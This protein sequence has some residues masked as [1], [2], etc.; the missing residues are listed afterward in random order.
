MRILQ[1][2]FAIY[3]NNPKQLGEDKRKMFKLFFE[4]VELQNEPCRREHPPG[5]VEHPA[6]SSMH[7]AWQVLKPRGKGATHHP[8]TVIGYANN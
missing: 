2:S 6:Q 5:P 7:K 3:S 4:T 8:L 1:D